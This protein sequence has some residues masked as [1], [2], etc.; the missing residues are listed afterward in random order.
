LAPTPFAAFAACCE[1]LRATPSKLEKV[2]LAAAFLRGLDSDERAAG[3]R[4][5]AGKALAEHDPRALDMGWVAVHAAMQPG[6]QRNLLEPAPLTLAEVERALDDIADLEGPASRQRK[7]QRLR[8]LLGRCSPEERGWLL[9]LLGGEMRTGASD[10]VVLEALAQASGA[11][12]EAVRR[13]HLLRGDLG[14][15]ALLGLEGGPEALA[16][17]RLRL[18]HP[19]RPML[20][21]LAEDVPD[22][23]SQLAGEVAWEHKFDGARIAIHKRGED[24]RV[25]SRRLTDVTAS[26]PEVVE[27]GRGL[28]AEDAVVEGEVVAYDAQAKP[29]PFQD[30]MRR[31]RRIR[32]LDEERARIPLTTH[33][34]DCLHA[35][36]RTLLDEPLRARWAELVRIAPPALLAPRLVTRDPS[37]AEAFLEDAL[38]R[39]HEGLMAKDL[40]SAYVPGRRGSFWLKIKRAHTLDCV[41]LAAER[42]SGR[43]EGWLS[44]LHLGVRVPEGEEALLVEPPTARARPTSRVPG[45]AMVGKTFKGLTDAMLDLLT[46]RL[47]ALAVDEEDWGVR[48]RPELVIEV[49]YDEIQRSPHYDSGFALRFARVKAVRE[50]KLAED[51]DTLGTLRKL[52]EAQARRKGS[53]ATES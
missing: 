34:F 51:A 46:Q 3:A 21:D 27:A 40:A 2:K 31:F 39:G 37:R 32:A 30:L 41:V 1:A 28:R 5:L 38:A 42:G 50:D 17:V 45:W 11:R 16:S 14:D 43:R 4:F 44:N 26:V 52:A 24:V 48:V 35:D 49:A 23:L 9:A 8:A 20:A 36:G 6:T 29:L 47:Q 13:A 22:A 25:F 53:L 19:L 7:E 33:V 15:V 10:G 18:F 12:P